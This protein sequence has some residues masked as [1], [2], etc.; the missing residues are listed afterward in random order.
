MRGKRF[1]GLRQQ[2]RQFPCPYC[3]KRFTDVLRHLN[4]RESKCG[5]WFTLPSHPT[6]P[7]TPYPP[8]PT[9]DIADIP[10]SPSIAN[11]ESTENALPNHPHP[12]QTEFPTAGKIYG[13]TKSFIDRFNDDKYAS[14]RAQNTYYPFADE[15]EWGLGSFLLRSGM[16]MQKVDEFL[17]LKL[18]L[19]F[20]VSPA[21]PTNYQ[22]LLRSRMPGLRFIPQGNCEVESR[23]YRVYRSGNSRLSPS[24]DMPQ[25]S[26]CSYSTAMPLSVSST[27][28]GT[29]FLRVKSTSARSD[30]IATRSK[31]SACT[32]SG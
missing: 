14:Y 10:P 22:L 13:R 30:S 19:C 18:V 21:P 7:T 23:C 28:L 24:P 27:Y 25:R 6:Q 9:D 4:H 8:D 16:S 15:E 1:R 5:R 29:P 3:R 17:G 26:Q 32:P 2:T 31:Q 11:F 12:F 20:S